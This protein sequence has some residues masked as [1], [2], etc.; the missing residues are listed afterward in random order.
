L[1]LLINTDLTVVHGRRYGLVGPNG[2]GKTT[3]MKLLARRK[4]P[5]PDFIDILL[6]EQEVVGDHRTAR[7]YYTC[8]WSSTRSL[9]V[10]SWCTSVPVHTRRILLPSL[11]TR[12]C[13]SST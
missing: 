7:P 2:M 8:F 12:S 5:V 11:A 4:L 10:S 9:N 13:F 6:V 3:I 1:E